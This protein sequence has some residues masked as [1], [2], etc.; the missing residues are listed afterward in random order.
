[1]NAARRM[2]SEHIEFMLPGRQSRG[3]NVDVPPQVSRGVLGAVDANERALTV[4]GV[5]AEL[6]V[7][8]LMHEERH[9]DV[10][11]CRNC[12]SVLENF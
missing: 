12:F 10:E 11:A 6:V 1:M 7:S 8:R 3:V 4:V 2:E 5:H 9:S